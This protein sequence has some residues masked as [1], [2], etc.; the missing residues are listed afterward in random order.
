MM[1]MVG[2]RM[3]MRVEGAVLGKSGNGGGGI[4][5]TGGASLREVEVVACLGRRRLTTLR[6]TVLM[7][8]VLLC[9]ICLLPFRLLRSDLLAKNHS[10]PL[11]SSVPAC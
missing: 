10:Q 2:L 7:V 11:P 4:L 1:M 9:I 8:L 6:S 3:T 5:L